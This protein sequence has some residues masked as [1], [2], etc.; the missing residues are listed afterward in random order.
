MS[1]I[2]QQLPLS[3]FYLPKHLPLIPEEGGNAIIHFHMPLL[4]TIRLTLP[5]KLY[6]LAHVSCSINCIDLADSSMIK[7]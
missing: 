2:L 6:P 4:S 1:P 5:L 3:S 7:M